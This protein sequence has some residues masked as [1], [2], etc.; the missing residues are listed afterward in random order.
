MLNLFNRVR[1]FVKNSENNAFSRFKPLNYLNMML[2][3]LRRN[4]WML[5]PRFHMS[6]CK[7]IDVDRPIFLLGTPGGGLTLVSRMLRRCRQVVSISGNYRYWSGADEMQLVFG[8]VLPP[9]LNL[10][11]DVPKANRYGPTRHWLYAIDALVDRYRHTAED[12][13]DDIRAS[14]LKILRWSIHTYAPDPDSARFI[15]KSQLYTVNVDFLNELLKNEQPQFLL[16]S[17][18]P[19]AMCY[20]SVAYGTGGLQNLEDQRSFNERLELAAQHW[21]NNM[22]LALRDGSDM[23]QFEHVRFEDVINHPRTT[24]RTICT[25]L[26]L[27]Y[28]ED[29][30]PSPH[31]RIPFGSK[32]EKKW[33]PLREHVNR[34]HL[35][36]LGTYQARIVDERCGALAEEFGYERPVD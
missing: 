35:W 2:Y 4:R 24:L 17:R 12:A 10:N 20:R 15:D 14:L 34:K 29:Y 27:P 21:A 30:I 3:A 18:N 22:K 32:Y 33:F 36:K 28:R 5:D 9:K 13:T 8:R 23:T 31:H 19:Y 1:K 7:H 11:H 16:V 25:L 26:D 6:D